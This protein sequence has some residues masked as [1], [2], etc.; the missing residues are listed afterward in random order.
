VIVCHCHGKSD[1]EIRDAVRNGAHTRK[2]VLKAC[3][4]GKSCGGC[5]PVVDE[6][7]SSET[8]SGTV[9]LATAVRNLA[10]RRAVA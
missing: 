5:I 8:E 3:S 7:I 2:R 10:G 9:D 1:R 4:A 6:I